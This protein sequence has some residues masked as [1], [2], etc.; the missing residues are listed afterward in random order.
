VVDQYGVSNEPN[1]GGWLQPQRQGRSLVSPHL[2]RAMAIAAYPRIKRG[3]P[4]SSALL[5]NLAPSG[6]NGGGRRG[7]IRPLQFLRE[8]GC[9]D[10]RYRRRRTGACANY[11]PI[12]FDALAHHPYSFFQA[13]IRPLRNR[14]DAGIGDTR[15]LLR[16]YDRLIRM[17]R[18]SPRRGR[19]PALY[20]TEFGYQTN[21]PDPFGGIPLRLQSNWLQEAAYVAWRAPRV[22][23]INQ[24]RL[25]DGALTGGGLARFREFQSGLL[26]RGGRAKPAYRTFPH[27]F[28]IGGGK[29]W[30]QVRPGGRRTVSLQYRRSGGA[31]RTRKR[32]RTDRR[33]YFRTGLRSRAG[34]YRFRY[35]RRGTS[36][37]ITIR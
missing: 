8:M 16:V 34:Q 29:A 20:Y 1:Q 3:D 22:R 10:S 23:G 32:I 30:G 11:T 2:Y 18:I 26:F 13:P 31:F 15:R 4:T 6:S 24:F 7:N 19:R 27:P 12:P 14:N 36:R 37:T 17:G 5:G 21:P 25:S 9:V 33:G 28:V 35:G